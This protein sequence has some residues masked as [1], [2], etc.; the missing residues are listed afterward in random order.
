MAITVAGPP[1]LT[2]SWSSYEGQRYRS[3]GGN[4]RLPPLFRFLTPR[5]NPVARALF[6]R[7]MVFGYPGRQRLTFVALNL[8]MAVGLL[9]VHAQLRGLMV[10][11]GFED[12]FRALVTPLMVGLGIYALAFF[13]ATMPLLEG[14]TREGPAIWVIKASPVEP[15]RFVHAKVRP[16][17]AFMPLTVVSAGMALPFVNGSSW[18]GMAMAMLGAVA[19][20]LAFLGVGAWAGGTYPNLDRHSNAPPDMV[21]AFYLMFGCLFLMGLMLLPVVVV[22]SLLPEL[23]VLFAL[24]MVLMG[25]LLM[26]VGIRAGGRALRRLEVG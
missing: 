7:E 3:A 16:L 13:Q 12:Y 6:R 10:E 20:Y 25:W 9:M 4:R 18:Q 23:G 14:V 1:A 15:W 2:H 8:A 21:L 24:F 5:R 17:M 19:V 26:W 11:E 22:G